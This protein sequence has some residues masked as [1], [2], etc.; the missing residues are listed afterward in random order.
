MGLSLLLFL[1]PRA[2][3]PPYARDKRGW[4]PEWLHSMQQNREKRRMRK[5]RR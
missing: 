3:A 5:A 1:A 2:L 4:I